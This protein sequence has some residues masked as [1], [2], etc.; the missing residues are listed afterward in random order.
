MKTL[1][2]TDERVKQAAAECSTAA[3]TLKTLFPEV[4]EEDNTVMIISNKDITDKLL[5]TRYSGNLA[6]KSIWL[7]PQYEWKFVMDDMYT[8][9]LQP[10]KKK[11]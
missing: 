1:T 9:V 8:R 3:R 11:P 10:F 2:I 7:D 4:F 6:F 5:C